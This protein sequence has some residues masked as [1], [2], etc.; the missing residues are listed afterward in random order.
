[1]M[2][3]AEGVLYCLQHSCLL[4]VMLPD[5]Q[6]SLFHY[7]AWQSISPFWV[8]LIVLGTKIIIFDATAWKLDSE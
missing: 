2:G 3:M 8:S 7:I 6:T 4:F 1:M 5:Q